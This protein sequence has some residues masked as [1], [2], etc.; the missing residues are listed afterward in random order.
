MRA[1]QRRRRWTLPGDPVI[2]GRGPRR[3]HEQWDLDRVVEWARAYAERQAQAPA[4]RKARRRA[5]PSSASEEGSLVARVTAAR[6][7]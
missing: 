7:R 3:R 6:K 4:P 5:R 2:V 1:E